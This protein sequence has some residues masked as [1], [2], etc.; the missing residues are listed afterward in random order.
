MTQLTLSERYPHFASEW[1]D[2][3]EKPFDSYTKGSHFQAI[4][5]CSNP[6]Q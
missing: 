3:N 2:K 4:W 1:S 6:D 5:S